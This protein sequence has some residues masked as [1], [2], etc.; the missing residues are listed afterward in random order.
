MK[1]KNI[2]LLIIFGI[3]IIVSTQNTQEVSLRYLF[4]EVKVPL[5]VLI[6]A[7]VVISFILGIIYSGVKRISK[8]RALKKK[9]KLKPRDKAGNQNTFSF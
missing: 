2:I 9:L 5:I 3:M 4:W 6:Y 8:D 1:I 7:T